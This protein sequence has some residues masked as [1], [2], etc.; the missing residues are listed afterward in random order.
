MSTVRYFVL[1]LLFLYVCLSWNC[2]KGQTLHIFMCVLDAWRKRLCAFN[3]IDNKY[4]DWCTIA[5]HCTVIHIVF[6]LFCVLLIIFFLF[7]S[8]FFF[9]CFCFFWLVVCFCVLFF[10]LFLFWVLCCYGILGIRILSYIYSFFRS[11]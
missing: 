9:Y 1:S 7:F 2:V 3:Y 4:T 6:V 11:N 5:Y 10:C 8:V